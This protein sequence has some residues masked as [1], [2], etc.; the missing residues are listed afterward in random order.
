ML[1]YFILAISVKERIVSRNLQ[2]A[3]DRLG[4]VGLALQNKFTRE[5][6]PHSLIVLISASKLHW[7][8]IFSITK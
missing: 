2:T 1:F 4:Y 6:F 5:E 8:F 3:G 7:E